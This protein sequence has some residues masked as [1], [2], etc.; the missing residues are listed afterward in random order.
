MEQAAGRS[1]A[2]LSNYR[3]PRYTATSSPRLSASH[4]T[5]RLFAL[6]AVR[7]LTLDTVLP[8]L[9]VATLGQTTPP[10]KKKKRAGKAQ[11]L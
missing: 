6:L 5:P 8:Y 11:A 7:T 1:F 2:A 9:G 3:L 10:R 4:T